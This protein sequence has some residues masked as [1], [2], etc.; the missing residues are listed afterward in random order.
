MGHILAG[1]DTQPGVCPMMIQTKPLT[2]GC[3]VLCRSVRGQAQAV[4]DD[5]VRFCETSE[6]PFWTFEKELLVR[7]AVL[8]C[9]LIRLFLT[10]RH[11]RF[12]VQ[13]FLKDGIYRPGDDY[14]ERFFQR[15]IDDAVAGAA[16][17]RGNYDTHARAARSIAEDCFSS[18]AVLARLLNAVGAA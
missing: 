5:L 6:L 16:E 8:G 17:I 14:A 2:S 10:A 13:P 9:W 4:Y 15:T 12:D 18:D 1:N 3:P 11:E 7:V